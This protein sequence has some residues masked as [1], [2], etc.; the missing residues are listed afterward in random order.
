MAQDYFNSSRPLSTK[1]QQ[2]LEDFLINILD[3]VIF[4]C[5]H[6]L[7]CVSGALASILHIIIL[8]KHGLHQTSSFLLFSMSVSVLFCS[9]SQPIRK[10]DCILA[11]FDPLLAKN[12][13]SYIGV[14]FLSLPDFF[15]AISTLHTAVIAV[16]RLIAVCFPLK[17]SM[18]SQL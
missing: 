4:C 7:L 18:L 3:R 11:L 17:M 15:I 2:E 6:H 5:F 14:Y 8:Y 16:E 10:L 13:G 12:T 9:I 1:L